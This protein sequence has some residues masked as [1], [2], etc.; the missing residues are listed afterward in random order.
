MLFHCQEVTRID[1]TVVKKIKA[2][3]KISNSGNS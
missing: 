1:G 3:I 2:I